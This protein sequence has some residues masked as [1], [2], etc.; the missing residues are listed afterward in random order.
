MLKFFP[1]NQKQASESPK[2]SGGMIK[3][4]HERKT[5]KLFSTRSKRRRKKV[6]KGR[7]RT[8]AKLEKGGRGCSLTKEGKIFYAIGYQPKE[9]LQGGG[10]SYWR[11]RRKRTEEAGEIRKR[12]RYSKK[13]KE[14]RIWA[15]RQKNRLNGGGSEVKS[16]RDV[17]KVW[18]KSRTKKNR[19]N[20][21]SLKK[22]TA[23]T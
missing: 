14:R 8:T 17:Y 2:C 4:N 11:N 5:E 15:S 19:G 18:S 3:G 12:F 20:T 16:R 21:G 9:R 23:K 6:V 22:Q 13:P 10:F 7:L 1:G